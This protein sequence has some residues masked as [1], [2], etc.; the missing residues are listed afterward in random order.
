MADREFQASC[1]CDGSDVE[2]DKMRNRTIRVT[3]NTTTIGD[4][5]GSKLWLSVKERIEQ[6]DADAEITKKSLNNGGAD[7]QAMI[8]DGPNRIVEFYILP[9]DTESLT[10][11]DYWWDAV[12]EFASGTRLQLVPPSRFTVSTPVTITT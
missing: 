4:I 12:I 5:T 1:V 6:D 10:E 11:G 3:I 2:I 9:A 7:A 8:V